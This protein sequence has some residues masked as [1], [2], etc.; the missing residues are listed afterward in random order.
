MEDSSMGIE[1]SDWECAI[2]GV[3]VETP[4]PLPPGWEKVKARRCKCGVCRIGSNHEK[5]PVEQE[6]D[7]CADCA[8]FLRKIGDFSRLFNPEGESDGTGH[9][10]MTTKYGAVVLL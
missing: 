9:W 4:F 5:Q 2:C 8:F 7:V 6:I 10:H 1:T 3:I